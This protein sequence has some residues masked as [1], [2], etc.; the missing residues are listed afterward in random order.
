MPRWGWNAQEVDK[1]DD[2]AATFH[3]PEGVL[4]LVLE[5]NRVIGS[6]GIVPLGNREG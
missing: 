1:L 4:L 6:G 3:L 5:E 2:P